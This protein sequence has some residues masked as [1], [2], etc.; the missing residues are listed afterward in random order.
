A[1]AT[2]GYANIAA[3][4]VVST[5]AHPSRL[6]HVAPPKNAAGNSTFASS[7]RPRQTAIVISSGCH[8]STK[9]PTHSAAHA[10]IPTHQ[11][12]YDRLSDR[13]GCRTDC[14]GTSGISSAG[15]GAGRARPE[16]ADDPE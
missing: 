16:E 5:V 2:S 13:Y 14:G 1:T 3:N 10:I 15:A 6:Y 9:Y 8:V 4:S 12:R 11:R 7:S